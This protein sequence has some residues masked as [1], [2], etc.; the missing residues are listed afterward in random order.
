MNVPVQLSRR[1]FARLLGGGTLALLCATHS[2]AIGTGGSRRRLVT[3]ALETEGLKLRAGRAIEILERHIQTGYLSGAVALIGRGPHAEVVAVGDQSFEA[4]RLLQRDSLFRITSMTKPITAAATLMLVDE[5]RL[6]LG[7]RIDRWL[8]ELAHPRVLRNINGALDDTVPATRAITVED[9]LTFRCGFGLVLNDADDYPVQR[10]IAQLKLPG[11]GPPDPSSPLGPDEWLRRLGTLPLMAQPG[12]TWMYNTGSSILGV[13]IARV[14]RK[15][16]P[17]VLEERI[18]GPLGMKDTGFMVPAVKRERFVSAYRP[19]AGHAQLFDAAAASPWIDAPAFAD[20]AAGL[21]ST[22]DD[23]FAFSHFLLSRGHPRGHRLLSREL[24]GEMTR[25]HLT[26]SQRAAAAPLL[27][28]R[29]G[30]G[31][32]MAVVTE[33]TPQGIPAGAYGWNGGFGTSWIADPV[34]MTSAIL[35]TQTLFTSPMPPAVHEEFWSA[36]FS[37]PVL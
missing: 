28:N 9:L 26:A 15:P 8:P 24:V 37:P 30:W 34:S 31:F 18:F 29:R 13:L 10:Q 27:G 36:V 33:T 32:G 14:A 4:P 1:R 21:V 20:G 17:L 5:G 12:E 2:Q 16:L 22:V 35:L 6:Q 19:E 25:D 11:F 23:Y 7:E 3:T